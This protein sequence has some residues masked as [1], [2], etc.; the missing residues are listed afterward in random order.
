MGSAKPLLALEGS[1]Y[2]AVLLEAVGAAR[3][4]PCVVLGA[5]SE[6]VRRSV[7]LRGADVVFNPDWETGMLSSVQAAVRHLEAASAVAALMLIPVDQ[8]R[9]SAATI[10]QVMDAW[11][12]DRPPVAVAAYRGRRGHP[13]LFARQVWDELL[14]APPDDGARAIMAA[15]SPDRL[16]VDVEDPWVV[17]DADTPSDH[18]AME[19]GQPTF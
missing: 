19:A 17:V 5:R 9:I 11:L 6:A 16:V 3:A 14:A 8:P 13:A 18:A 4:H 1:T 7:D 2:L 10:R 15:Y 12:A